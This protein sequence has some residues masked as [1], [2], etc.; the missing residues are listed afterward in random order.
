MAKSAMEKKPPTKV[1]QE[2]MTVEDT[3]NNINSLNRKAPLLNRYVTSSEIDQ[4]SS[5]KHRMRIQQK[6][7]YNLE[8]LREKIDKLI[9]D[10]DNKKR[11]ADDALKMRAIVVT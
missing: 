4:S 6:I 5:P 3:D 8:K 1:I 11:S 9:S 7:K 10:L 2:V